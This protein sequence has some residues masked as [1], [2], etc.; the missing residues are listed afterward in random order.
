[1]SIVTHLNLEE[2]KIEHKNLFQ[3]SSQKEKKEM[4]MDFSPWRRKI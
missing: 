2:G 4:E 3:H 1:M